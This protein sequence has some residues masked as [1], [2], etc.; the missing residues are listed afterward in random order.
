[1]T[2]DEAYAEAVRHYQADERTATTL[3]KFL[4]LFRARGKHAE[5]SLLFALNILEREF[6]W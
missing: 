5:N 1:M 2:A 3:P 4:Q 6:Y